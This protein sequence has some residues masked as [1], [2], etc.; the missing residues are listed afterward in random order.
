MSPLTL[1]FASGETSLSVRRFSV[2]EALSTLFEIS[3]VAR[4]PNH[5]LDFE[6][7][8]GKGAGL[9]IANGI[10]FAASG[11]M[12]AWT[13]VCSYFEQ[14][15]AEPTGLSTY[16]LRIVPSLWLLTHR[17]DHRVFQRATIPDI[18]DSILDEWSL[19][20]T[21]AIDRGS[22][23]KLNYK[24][25]YGESDYHFL[26]RLLEEAGI[27]YTFPDD[28][29]KGSILTL[30]DKLHLAAPRV[31]PLLPYVDNPNET[32]DKELV[33]KVR[34]S[35]DVRP[36]AYRIRDHDLRSPLFEL[37]G[38]AAK[39]PAPE[40]RYEQHVYEPGAFLIESPRGGDTPVADD[41]MVA[42]H[43]QK[44]GAERAQRALEGERVHKRGITFETNAADLAPGVIFSIDHHPHAE[45]AP[46]AKLLAT[47]RTI[48]GALG[49]AWSTSGRAVF[50]DVPYRP[51][52]RTRKPEVDGVQSAIVVGPAGQEIHTDELGRVRVQFPWDRKGKKDDNSSCWIRVSHGWAGAGFGV[53]ATPRV[54]QE[55]LVGFL[56]GDPDQPIIVGRVYNNTNPVPYKLPDHKTRSTW[57]SDSSIGSGGFNEI[58]MED[59][60]GSE[61]VYMQAQ[62]NLRKLVKNDETITIGNNRKKL[63]KGDETETTAA[64]R[65]EATGGNRTEI[66]DG[67]R[68]TVIGGTLSTLA[69]S[70]Q[71]ELTLGDRLRRVVRD[72]HVWV[73]QT[74][75]ERVEGDDHLRVKGSRNEQVDG[76][77]SL[78]VGG[79]QQIKAG[80]S[81]LVE[82]GQEIHLKAATALVIE[83]PDLTLRGDGGFIRIDAG[84]VTIQGTLVKI[85]SGGSAGS[86]ADARPG[87]AED[88][89]EAK[90]DEPKKP[91]IDD[92]SV[93]GLAQ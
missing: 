87:S 38:D 64:N 78:S 3:V 55:V 91:D 44:Y 71:I 57:K 56:A 12:R 13:G 30:G 74:R 36:G 42:R 90:I 15:Q 84:G 76:T 7:I 32:P 24:V 10:A 77:Q 75:R 39:A 67:D 88:P 54:G 72:E 48:E 89:R 2:H 18:V 81:H 61:L 73:T 92:V 23:P 31:P 41:K 51:M 82:A 4:S 17:R 69:K 8:V 50:A 5:D 85:N 68:T 37:A 60:K 59:L 63:V 45:L 33:T 28:P 40:D 29:A 49:E 47:E 65:T 53:I 34:L 16:S 22:Y 86:A 93:T 70:D 80:G 20:R 19:P 1:T 83:A 43:D 25:Q 11:E 52:L 6:A 46:A 79:D 21:W 35:H 27:A 66:T 62:K 58:M 9:H 26:T 14:M